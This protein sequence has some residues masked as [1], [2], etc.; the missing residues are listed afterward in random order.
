VEEWPDADQ[1]LWR[2][3]LDGDIDDEACTRATRWRPRT[4]LLN[5]QGYGR[6]VNHLLRSGVD[7]ENAPAE[8]VTPEQV[9]AYLG[10]LR[11]QKLADDSICSRI[12]QLH[13]A[14]A[15]MA[16]D[17]DWGWLKRR[18][19]RLKV[20]VREGRRGRQVTLFTGDI[21]GRALKALKLMEVEG[22]GHR[23]RSATA[24]RNWLM[25]AM[26]TLVPLRS[27][28]F[29]EL[30][31]T[32]HLRRVRDDWVIEIPANEAKG[33]REIMMPVPPVLHRHLHYYLEHARP[34]LLAGRDSDRFWISQL[35]TGMIATSVSNAIA[36]FTGKVFG[37]AINAHRFRHIAATTTVMAAPKMVE[38]A[39]ALLTHS[40]P[41]TT[42][43]HYVL[44]QS[45]AVGREHAALIAKLRRRLIPTI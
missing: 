37:E 24:Y 13:A 31:L 29:A 12:S 27:H 36:T 43:D 28:N 34:V 42:Q 4:R 38:A 14:I 8:R 1:D 35:H 30:T 45:L 16:P 3:A 2:R 21:L 33:K 6:W 44:G 7:L 11:S 9:R 20:L 18:R 26:L 23:V 22:I 5:R 19:N 32:R 40:S 10:E 41:Q 17:H 25:L 15:A 39:R